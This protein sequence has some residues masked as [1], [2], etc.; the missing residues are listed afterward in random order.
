M[1]LVDARTTVPSPLGPLTLSV[2]NGALARD[3][4]TA[5][6]A[7]GQACGRNPI[8]IVQPC[9]RVIGGCGDG[10]FSAPGG[11]ATKAWLIAHERKCARAG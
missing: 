8:P 6:R 3:L 2:R 1:I 10:G 9:H 7:V 5:A 11:L 4:D